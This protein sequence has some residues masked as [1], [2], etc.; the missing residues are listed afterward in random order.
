MHRQQ[1]HESN[2]QTQKVTGDEGMG[3]EGA[4][5]RASY[6]PEGLCSRRRPAAGV[7]VVAGGGGHHPDWLPCCVWQ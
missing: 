3:V 5:A 6:W 7:L 4:K 2:K 1:A